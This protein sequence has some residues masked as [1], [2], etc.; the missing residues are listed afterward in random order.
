MRNLFRMTVLVAASIA[1]AETVAGAE[2][3]SSFGGAVL[4]GKIEAGD[5]DKLKNFIR[6]GDFFPPLRLF[7]YSPGGN[8]A[9]A[10]KLG[11]LV[12]S[13]KVETVVPV[14]LSIENRKRLA[15]P[16]KRNLK[17]P[18]PNFM[19]ASACFFV[20]VGGTYRGTDDFGFLPI[21][22]IHRPYL[23]DNELKGLGSAQAIAA[24]RQARTTVETYLK[25]MGVPAKYVDQMFSVGK[26][27]VRRISE[28][29]FN[30]DFNGFISEL[31][32]WVDARCDKRTDAE[33]KIWESLKSKIY[34]QQTT[35]EKSMTDIL[36]KK[37]K[38]QLDCENKIKRELFV[39]AALAAGL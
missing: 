17:D 14:E 30:A 11:R 34:A 12:R 26:D 36:E 19:C 37:Y 10:M 8:M 15:A 33:K 32:D 18:E 21:L 5:S 4:E 25:E 27:E 31:K 23:S 35:A 20:F 1:T 6:H 7:L 39:R 22:G 3:R 16:D 38:E 29:E 13:L 24:A 9:E 28:G 2:I